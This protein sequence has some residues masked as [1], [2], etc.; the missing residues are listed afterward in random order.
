LRVVNAPRIVSPLP[1][2]YV[3]D[4]LLLGSFVQMGWLD[5]PFM[6]AVMESLKAYPQT[7][8]KMEF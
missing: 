2:G 8:S 4:V 7:T 6:I 3:A 5:A 1:G